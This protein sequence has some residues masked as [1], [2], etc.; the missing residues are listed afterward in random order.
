MHTGLSCFE[1]VARLNQVNIDLRSVIREFGITSQ[2]VSPEEIV[3]IAQKYDFKAKNKKLNIERFP[4]K[5]PLP[6]VFQQKDGT[7]GI[8][9]KHDNEKSS[10]LVFIPGE[11]SPAEMSFDEFNT[12]T[13]NEFIVLSYKAINSNVKFGFGWFFAEVM[14]YRQIIG[15][16]LLGSFVVQLFGLA[17]PLFTQVILDKVI[18]NRS[19]TTL[20]VLGVAFVA[21]TL[22]E[23]GLNISRNYIFIHTANKIDA[24][25]GAKLFKHL[26]S[27]PYAY[28]ESR[29]VGNIVQRVRELDNIREFITNKSVSVIIDLM[30]SLVFVAVMFVYSPKLTGIVLGFV[31][32][33][34]LIYLAVTPEL[35]Q[36]LEAKFQMGA[37]NN[38][39]LVEAITG[40]QTVKSLAI[41]GSMQRRW[42]DY[43]GKYL[44]SSFSLATIGNFTGNISNCLQKFMTITVLYIGVKLVIENKLSIGQLIAFQMFANQF[45]SPVLRLV[46]LFNDFQ[47]AL[48]GVDRLGD[49]LNQPLEIQSSKA[50]T[51]PKIAGTVKFDGVSFRYNQ[52]SPHVLNKISFEI[53]EGSTVG[54]VGRSG[55]G[56][57]TITKLLQRLYMPS[58]GAIYIDGIDVRHLNPMWL[59]TKIGMVLQENYLFSGT[60]RD[61]ICLPLPNAPIEH[62]LSVAEIA[63]AHEFISQLPEGYDTA[64]GER[65][66]TLSGGQRQR[67]AIARALITNPK[68]LIFDEATS[69]LDYESEKIIRNNVQKIKQGRTMFV[70]A[71]RLSTVKDCDV[72]I[73]MDRGHIIEMGTHDELIAK[74]GY[75]KYLC[76]QQE[77]SYAE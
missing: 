16:V 46:N 17:T 45:T 75:Y 38:S 48:L 76:S 70:I 65:G 67:V 40:V 44:K 39:Y 29:K 21:V 49:I 18:V 14:K 20:D 25:L 36:R 12:S 66:S 73:A 56:K 15:E 10:V 5:Y 53:K 41:E 60:I 30:F 11:N 50:I 62:I 68:I 54:I 37:Q 74:D 55:S 61:N 42:E 43:L 35:R 34:A 9:L 2:E 33:V 1:A 47:Q 22:F 51:L 63:G 69:A 59:R 4:E 58:E 13:N 8:L 27:I 24:K 26:F 3:R 31:G 32:A 71:H 72:I 7:Y 64:V 23:L 77:E 19:M 6:A 28:F 52:D 57:S